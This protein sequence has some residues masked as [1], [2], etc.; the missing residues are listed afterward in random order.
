MIIQGKFVPDNDYL[1]QY[2]NYIDVMEHIGGII[3]EEPALLKIELDRLKLTVDIASPEQMKAATEAA[4][5]VYLA[6]AFLS[7]SDRNI[8]GR[9]L[10]DLENAY[11]YGRDEYPRTL[12]AAYN[13]LVHWRNSMKTT[14]STSN[15]M[16][17]GVAFTNVAADEDNKQEMALTTNGQTE[18]RDISHIT[19]F[20]CGEKGH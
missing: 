19:C 9:M 12:T 1:D 15:T 20:N 4:K 14:E 3:G 7:G 2:S 13:L 11:L 8:Y 5:Q 18:K 16:S 6:V 10:D 17:E